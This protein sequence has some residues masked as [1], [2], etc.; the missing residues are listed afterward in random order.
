MQMA[1]MAGQVPFTQGYL[2]Q[3]SACIGDRT[4]YVIIPELRCHYSRIAALFREAMRPAEAA[5]SA[6]VDTAGHALYLW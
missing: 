4:L 1:T 5:G 2:L 3:A 6:C